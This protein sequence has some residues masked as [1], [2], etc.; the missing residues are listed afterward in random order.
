MWVDGAG[1]AQTPQLGSPLGQCA[2]LRRVGLEK[3]AHHLPCRC[4]SHPRGS[5][6]HRCYR[7]RRTSSWGHRSPWHMELHRP[8]PGRRGGE[9][10]IRVVLCWLAVVG[11]IMPS[12]LAPIKDVHVL[13]PGICECYFT[14]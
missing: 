9:F 11:R 12:P 1:I 13:I 2:H 10:W 8:L 6:Y 5:R 14:W 4:R 3:K 7:Y